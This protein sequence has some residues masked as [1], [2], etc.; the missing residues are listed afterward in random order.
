MTIKLGKMGVLEDATLDA[1]KLT[2]LCGR[3]NTGKSYLTYSFYG[4]LS[5]LRDMD[6]Y[7]FDA[8]T[9]REL[10]EKGSCTVD[11]LGLAKSY[12]REMS[13]DQKN[14]MMRF[15]PRWFGRAE[16][17][18]STASLNFTVSDDD[19]AGISRRLN[20]FEC[21][22]PIKTQEDYTLR[23]T[24]QKGTTLVTCTYVHGQSSEEL[25][26]GVNINVPESAVQNA[27]WIIAFLVRDRLPRPFI[28]G[29]ERTGVSV[30][31]EEFSLYRALAYDDVKVSEKL[32][33]LRERFSFSG[34][35]IATR[36]DMDF[37]LQLA[38]V[39]REKKSFLTTKWN[40]SIIAAF[41][42]IVGGHYD[43]DKDSGALSFMPKGMLT[44]LSLHE[45]SSSVRALCELYFYLAYCAKRGDV[46]VID[47][48]EM[49]LHPGA[50]RRLARF[51]AMLTNA[52]IRVFITT[53]SDYILRE[54]NA[55]VRIESLPEGKRAKILSDHAI[56]STALV[57]KDDV[58][59][60]VINDG[61]ANRME[62]DL[63]Y[64]FA[65]KSFDDTI[66][67]FN[68]LYSDVCDASEV[69]D[70]RDCRD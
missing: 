28:I 22:F 49:N 8:D 19:V 9:T 15:V 44:K 23:F 56:P 35:P 45:S 26:K 20:S 52:D 18:P 43:I 33:T 24:K 51:L 31:K 2:I 46:L 14:R 39:V 42:D 48:P 21:D 69:C 25:Y 17:L 70:V 60:Y 59:I 54:I 68:A 10:V 30:F 61:C 53:H 34:Y 41:E 64:G 66:E 16:E 36:K 3:N 1:G 58:S 65:V 27:K 55:L 7:L 29:S 32:R 37:V 13:V 6:R 47:E 62:A 63:Q 57:K 38:Q 12:W 5:Y 11:L 4:V 50:Q 67:S 40:G